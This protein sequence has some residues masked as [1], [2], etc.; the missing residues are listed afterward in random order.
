MQP[1]KLYEGKAKIIWATEHP[2]E[3]AQQFKDDATAFDGQK[4][5]R[6][7]SKGVRNA[8]IS[9]ILFKLLEEHGISTQLVEQIFEDTLLCKKLDMYPVEVVVRNY[10]AGSICKRLGFEE[11]AAMKKPMLEFFLKDDS[12]GDPLITEAHIE[13][14]EL[15]SEAERE[16]IKR[17]ALKINDV[18]SRFFAERNILLVDFKLEFGKDA[19]GNIVLG[20]EISP[21]TCRLWDAGTR[22]KLDKDRFRRDLGEVEE[23]YEEV[24]N[25]VEK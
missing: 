15:V 24:L 11:G 12:L 22:K 5:G 16:E 1:Q 7:A 6:I 4:K 23:A 10:A 17:L 21:D 25:R 19:A 20:D 18:L 9:A 2:E 14:L 3:V 8:R 13:E